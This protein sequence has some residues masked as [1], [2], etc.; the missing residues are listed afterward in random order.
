M[1]FKYKY[2]GLVTVLISYVVN[3]HL[4]AISVDVFVGALDSL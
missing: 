4:F 1:S 3:L 2:L